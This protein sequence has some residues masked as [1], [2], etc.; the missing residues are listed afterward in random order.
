MSKKEM[1][2]EILDELVGLCEERM[3]DPFRK[4][5]PDE[6]EVEEEIAEEEM[7]YDDS[8][9]LIDLYSKED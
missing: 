1:D 8:Q 9:D 2:I 4:K 3:A 6:E 5:K 7:P